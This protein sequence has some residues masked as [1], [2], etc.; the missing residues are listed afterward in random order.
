[1][2]REG[3]KVIHKIRQPAVGLEREKKKAKLKT[4]ILLLIISVSL[5]MRVFFISSS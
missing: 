5:V 2:R 3:G 1:M 4:K